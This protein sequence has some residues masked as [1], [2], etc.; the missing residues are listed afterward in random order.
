MDEDV[1][2]AK[3]IAAIDEMIIL[4]IARNLPTPFFASDP[5]KDVN[6]QTTIRF[7]DWGKPVIPWN[8]KPKVEVVE[9]QRSTE[10]FVISIKKEPFFTEDLLDSIKKHYEDKYGFREVKIA[11]RGNVVVLAFLSSKDR[12]IPDDVLEKAYGKL[13]DNPL[14][15][16][17]DNMYVAYCDK[18]MKYLGVHRD[19]RLK[20]VDKAIL[21]EGDHGLPLV[22]CFRLKTKSII[23]TEKREE[24]VRSMA[25]SI[26]FDLCFSP[27]YYDSRW[28]RPDKPTR[29][30]YWFYVHREE[31]GLKV[32]EPLALPVD[33]ST[34][35]PVGLGVLK[36]HRYYFPLRIPDGLS[37]ETRIMLAKVAAPIADKW[38]RLKGRT[39]WYF[40]LHRKED[41]LQWTIRSTE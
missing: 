1:R 24:V 20:K 5:N 13:E 36:N 3:A 38:F 39:E 30:V 19:D 25:R 6:F 32:E 29:S 40:D 28:E 34:E 8:S 27:V 16:E 18:G 11:I 9:M 14:L 33:V 35:T 10:C 21:Y 2:L 15:A 41:W 17:R 4:N 26:Y 37:K 12:T 31:Y 7:D 22:W 23:C